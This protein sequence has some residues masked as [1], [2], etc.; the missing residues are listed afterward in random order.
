[1]RD[2]VRSMKEG[3]IYDGIFLPTPRGPTDHTTQFSHLLF[4][5]DSIT[6]CQPVCIYL[7][8]YSY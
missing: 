1:M 7:G 6:S 8:A 5:V 2:D 4:M 3:W